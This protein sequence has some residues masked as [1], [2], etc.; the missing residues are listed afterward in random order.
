MQR[1]QKDIKFIEKAKGLE[2]LLR[3]KQKNNKFY[4]FREYDYSSC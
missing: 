4:N 2:N 1:L 3:N